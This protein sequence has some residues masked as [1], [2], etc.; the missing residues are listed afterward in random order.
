MADLRALNLVNMICLDEIKIKKDTATDS[1]PSV[2]P[3]G[4]IFT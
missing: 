1:G 3:S 2:S 4:G